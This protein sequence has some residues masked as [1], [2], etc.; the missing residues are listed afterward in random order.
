MGMNAM[1]FMHLGLAVHLI[2]EPTA[3]A[4]GPGDVVVA[5]SGSGTTESVL[6][7][8]RKARSAGARIVALTTSEDSPLSALADVSIIV[9]AAGKQNPD[10]A[11][12][13]Q[14]AGSLFEQTVV[15]TLDSLFHAIWQANEIVTNVLWAR[16]ANWE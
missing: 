11:T 6:S 14:Y 13:V 10:A 2:G 9:A 3:P 1:R 12:T 16:H 15:L 8:V 4:I 7:I 5:P